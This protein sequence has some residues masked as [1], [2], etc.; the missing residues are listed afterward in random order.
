MFLSRYYPRIC[1][2]CLRKPPKPLSQVS[3]CQVEIRIEYRALP[4]W[5]SALYDAVFS[6]RRVLLP[7]KEAAGSSETMV[8]ICQTTQCHIPADSNIQFYLPDIILHVQD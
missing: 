4:L 6:S 7:K 3:R 5:Q 8:T 2:E 1:L